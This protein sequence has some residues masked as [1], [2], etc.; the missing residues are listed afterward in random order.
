MNG[1]ILRFTSNPIRPVEIRVML[2]PHLIPGIISILVMMVTLT[3]LR[4]ERKEGGTFL[5]GPGHVFFAADRGAVFH[6]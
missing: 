5:P 2:N 3:L 6:F 1:A 4:M